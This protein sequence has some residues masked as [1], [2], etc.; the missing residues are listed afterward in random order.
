[1]AQSMDYQARNE[2]L[3]AP[4]SEV[5]GYDNAAPWQGAST[6]IYEPGTKAANAAA[7]TGA[8]AARST[9]TSRR[10]P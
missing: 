5:Y 8:V 7:V 6:N 3:R 2:L 4:G 9:T 10:T 1:M